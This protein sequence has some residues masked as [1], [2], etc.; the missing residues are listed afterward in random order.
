T[1]TDLTV[2]GRPPGRLLASSFVDRDGRF[3]VFGGRTAEGQSDETWTFDLAHGQWSMLAVTDRPPHRDSAMAAYVE[4][5]ERF[6]VFGGN[7][8]TRLADVWELRRVPV[9]AS[10]RS[11]LDEP[12][13]SG[14]EAAQRR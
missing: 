5:E 13:G 1:W 3:H 8:A 14:G 12:W 9:P 6:L 10:A 4:D 2:P 7:A 11:L